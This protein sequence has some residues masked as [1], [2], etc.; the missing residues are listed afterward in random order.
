[1]LL[2]TVLLLTLVAQ[3]LVLENGLLRT[4]PMGWLAWE[5]FRC[6]IDCDEDPKNCISER[7]FMEMADLMAQDG[8]R[9]LGYVYLNIDD[10]WIGERDDR[11]RLV[12]DSKRFPH[13]ITFLADYAHS[14]GL[15][16]GIYAD[17]GNLT[18]MGFPG[19]TLDKVELDAQTF[20][21]WKV[22]MLKLDG[23]FSTREERVE[24][25]PKMSAALNATGR[26]IAFSCS[27]PA[28]EGGLPPEVNYTLLANICNLWRNYDDI[29]DS[30][31]SVLFILDW[32]VKHQD[33]LQ[34]V[35]GPGHWNDPDMLLIG[36][37]GLS[38]EQARAQMALWTVL[39]APLFMSTDL[40]TISPQNVNIL[41]NPLMIKINQDPLGIQGRMILKEKSLIQVF[42]RPLSGDTNVVV[43]FSRRTDMPFRYHSSLAKLNF[44]S[45][46]IYEA[47]DVFSG[48]IIS[49]LRDDTSFTVVI[50][51]SGVVMW[52]LYPIQKMQKTVQ[53]SQ[54]PLMRIW[55]V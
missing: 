20:A 4:P 22:D 55:D 5:R 14:L 48:E 44:S 21:E 43:F 50:N 27:W 39:A 10:C 9:D 31:R 18:C 41:Q 46:R 15:K 16:L 3:V 35:A 34:P 28:Y 23:C 42:K 40:R 51:P 19:T 33:I 54:V 1:M 29:Q 32:F 53:K 2:K 24:G 13:G 8:W 45:S 26:S 11:G 12:P 37:F 30:W 17:M 7:L 38:Y 52:Y 47:Q 25:Y 36:N 49:G 6:N